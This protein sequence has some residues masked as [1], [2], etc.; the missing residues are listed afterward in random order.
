LPDGDKEVKRRG[1][2]K[3]NTRCFPCG[4]SFQHRLGYKNHIKN[5]HDNVEP[6]ENSDPVNLSL[7]DERISCLICLKKFTT[8]FGLKGHIQ[9]LHLG[10]TDEEVKK[11]G[12]S[13]ENDEEENVVEGTATETVEGSGEP[14][15]ETTV[16]KAEPKVL[17]SDEDAMLIEQMYYMMRKYPCKYCPVRF[18]NKNKLVMHEAIHEVNKKPVLCPYCE[19]SYSK[20][21][22]LK[23]H[24]TKIHPGKPMPAPAPPAQK[25]KKE[26]ESS[27]T[28]TT[29]NATRNKK[30]GGGRKPV[31]PKIVVDTI[32]ED[33][34]TKYKCPHCDGVFSYQKGCVRHIKTLHKDLRAIL[35]PLCPNS[36]LDDKGFYQHVRRIHPQHGV[37]E[38]EEMA[39]SDDGDK[40]SSVE[41]TPEV[42]GI[43]P[44]SNGTDSQPSVD[45]SQDNS[46]SRLQHTCPVCPKVF[47]N[48]GS[49]WVHKRTT[50]PEVFNKMASPLTKV[51]SPLTKPAKP[52]PPKK[53]Y[54]CQICEKPYANY[55]SLYMH[56]KTKH[57]PGSPSANGVQVL[58][59]GGSSLTPTGRKEKI[60]QCGQCPKRYAELKG[61][62]LHIEKMHSSPAVQ[63]HASPQTLEKASIECPYCPNIYSR[64][65]KV[66][67]HIRQKHPDQEVPYFGR[68]K[69]PSK[70]NPMVATPSIPRKSPYVEDDE[71]NSPY[72]KIS[73]A[74]LQNGTTKITAFS[75]KKGNQG[76]HRG[77]YKPKAYV[78][79]HCGKGYSDKSRYEN[80]VE[81]LHQTVSDP[82]RDIGPGTDI[83]VKNHRVQT[84]YELFK[85]VGVFTT[86]Q[87]YKCARYAPV[88]HDKWVLTEEINKNIQKQSII[89][90]LRTLSKGEGGVYTIGTE[91]LISLLKMVGDQKS[92]RG[93]TYNSPNN[94]R[95]NESEVNND[96]TVNGVADETDTI[97]TNG[98]MNPGEETRSEEYDE[99]EDEE[100][101]EDE[102]VDYADEVMVQPVFEEGI[103]EG[104]ADS[105]GMVLG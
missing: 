90:T 78:C 29:V 67:E 76:G 42:N 85:V 97:S 21:D 73:E 75:P 31:R 58:T 92:N 41:S 17:I 68:G 89:M 35:C 71:E 14:N 98:S 18:N 63:S 11:S 24:L 22:K 104:D 99:E 87:R 33:G 3:G 46:T 64:R 38:E 9:R 79:P 88:D 105:D 62:A 23:K 53:D 84:G 65:D 40:E 45:S 4:K 6:E 25:N 52:T 49:L 69:S 28:S 100:D 72:E 59:I 47:A 93:D 32:E 7:P 48:Q 16:A 13:E 51:A 54:Y 19:K 44:L 36:Y 15:E 30:K 57:P 10:M 102:V 77:R 50:H 27:K 96:E 20:R 95:K 81:T 82:W 1:P 101:E 55:M 74:Y 94:Y 80:H 66:N 56:K 86:G 26:Q 8:V 61:L 70:P 43:D 60:H 5:K 34:Q 2:P 12:N 37:P 83:S 103:E 91:E 39:D